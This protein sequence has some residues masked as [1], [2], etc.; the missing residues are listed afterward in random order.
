MLCHHAHTLQ[1]WRGGVSGSF[2]AQQNTTL[3]AVFLFTKET[4]SVRLISDSRE[5][6]AI[7]HTH[8]SNGEVEF[9]VYFMHNKT[10]H[11]M[12]CFRLRKKLG[13]SGSFLTAGNV[14]LPCTHTAAMERWSFW[15]ISCTTKH[16][17]VC[18][19]SV[20]KRKLDCR[21]HF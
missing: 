12:L 13:V 10:P 4:W 8:C 6:R 20:N 19:V 2:H 3:Y 7:M 14:M 9:L 5:C 18:C 11:C 21:A 17:I 1:Q 15:F 16:H